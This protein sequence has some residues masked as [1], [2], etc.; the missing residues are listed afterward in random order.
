MKSVLLGI[1][2][3]LSSMNMSFSQ[4][5]EKNNQ[6]LRIGVAGLSHSHVHGILG[7]KDRGDIEIVGF[8][9]ADRELAQRFADQ[10]GFSMDMVYPTIEDMLDAT[11]PDAVTAFNSI[12]A[13]LETVEK[14]APRGVHVM[15]EKPLAVNMEHAQKMAALAK[16][17]NIQ[18]LTNYETT[19]YATNHKTY[20]MV[21][22]DKSIGDL[23]KIVV[24]D[25]HQGPKEIGVN[26]EFLDWLTDPV[27]NGGG[28][29]ID[30]GCYG[31]NLITW[32]MKGQRPES[33][34]AVLQTDKP[35]VYPKVD[36]EATII[37][38]YPKM[39]GIIQ[40]SWNWPFSRKDMHV[41][42]QTG[43]IYQDNRTDMR[44]RLA[45]KDAE[46]PVTLAEREAPF[47]DPFAWLAGVLNGTIQPEPYDLSSLE[48]NL[49]VV[50][51]LDTAIRSAR[52]GKTIILDSNQ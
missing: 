34:T 51:I 28:A 13:H 2:I 22:S 48:N 15:V 17:Y 31:A 41:Y 52:D 39:Q 43:Y 21:H 30:F 25:G 5:D 44:Y 16:K 49:I 33:V 32:L 14:C 26:Q 40:A 42:G 3:L 36:D 29:V 27:L 47:D 19:W 20:D 4:S 38:K 1:I 12:Y 18:L 50:E 23:R 9:E 8:A 46:T 24:H 10:Y 7:R 35:D 45:E 6:P 11:K 37:V